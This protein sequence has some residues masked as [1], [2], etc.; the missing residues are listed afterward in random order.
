MANNIIDRNFFKDAIEEF[1]FDYDWYVQKEKK[2]DEYHRYVYDY[3]KRTI[4]GSFQDQGLRTTI[5]KTGNI[6]TNERKFYCNSWYRI[7]IGDF[8]FYDNNWFHVDEVQ[9]IDEYGVREATLK[10]VQ[11]S[12]YNDLQ[13]YVKCLNGEK[14][15]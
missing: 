15:L 5:S 11:L 2:L 10:M 14:I 6:Q 1:A 9:A 3:E 8:I 13:E 7:K 4:H 12:A